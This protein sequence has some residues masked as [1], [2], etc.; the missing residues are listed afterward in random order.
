[1]NGGLV[2][3]PTTEKLEEFTESFWTPRKSL[4]SQTRQHYVA[5]NR[6]IS[7]Q[8]TKM[9]Y[10]SVYGTQNISEFLEWLA[11][12]SLGMQFFFFH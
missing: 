12:I 2:H 7:E 4:E 6:Y 8:T 5:R 1:M 9:P 3:S 11:S 10:A